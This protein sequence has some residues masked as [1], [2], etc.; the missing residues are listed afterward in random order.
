MDSIFAP[1]NLARA[2]SLRGAQA[3]LRRMQSRTH[4]L[5]EGQ[6]GLRAFLFDSAPERRLD[7]SFSGQYII[8]MQILTGKVAAARVA[9]ILHPKYQ[10]HGYSVHLTARKIFSI[11]SNGQIDFGGSEYIAAGRIEIPSQRL[12]REDKYQWWELGR[13][14]YFVECNEALDLAENEIALIEPDDRL[15]RTGAW[16]MP[17]TC[18]DALSRCSSCLKWAPRGYV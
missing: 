9:G 13:G 14:S 11:E 8:N 12:R 6:N 18:A 15:L 17:F 5:L 3:A 7:A 1:I 16:H 4:L 2:Q 10:V